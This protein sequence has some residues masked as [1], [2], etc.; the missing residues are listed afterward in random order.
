VLVDMHCHYPMHLLVEGADREGAGGGRIPDPPMNVTARA[1]TRHH[2]RHRR[3]RSLVIRIA[4]NW[5]N[6]R[7]DHWRVSLAELERGGVGAVYSVLYEPFAEFDL[8]Q[9]YGAAPQSTYFARLI[10]L[11]DQVEEDLSDL[12]PEGKRHAVVKTEGELNAALA[13][14]KVA[15][16]HCVEGGFHLGATAEEVTANVATL[17]Q[18]GVV[19]ITLAHLFWRKVATDAPALPFLK[20]WVYKLL[21]RQPGEGLNELGKVAVEAMYRE[22]ILIDLSHMSER[23]I[24]DTFKLLGEL[25]QQHGFEPKQRPVIATHA[26]YRFR[27]HGQEYMLSGETVSRIAARDGVIGLIMARH[28]LNDGVRLKNPDDAAE[29]LRVMKLH[30]DAI[31]RHVPHHTNHHVAIGS[32]LDGFIKPTVAGIDTAGDMWR[33]EHPLRETYDADADAILNGNALRMARAALGAER[34]PPP[35]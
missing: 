15:F 20:D 14:G 7:D 28:Q 10:E 12:D 6:Y 25:D 35:A 34:V 11:L 17:K 8:E 33:L 32:D 1:L 4:A 29:T 2:G 3:L 19:Y 23:S 9:P 5:F 30:I 31:R 27:K 24:A 16:M 13:A 18:R 21:F 26:G 22:G